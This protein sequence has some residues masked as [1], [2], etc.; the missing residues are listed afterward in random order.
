M[1]ENSAKTLVQTAKSISPSCQINAPLEP[2]EGSW[3]VGPFL[4]NGSVYSNSAEVCISHAGEVRRFVFTS[5]NDKQCY[6]PQ[7]AQ[8][9]IPSI[10]L[11]YASGSSFPSRLVVASLSEELLGESSNSSWTVGEIDMADPELTPCSA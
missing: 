5:A 1:S 7:N 4:I 11:Y 10:V 8:G 3:V 9:P 6:T 2:T